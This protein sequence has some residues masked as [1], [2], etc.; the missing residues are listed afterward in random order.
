[1]NQ[2]F[3]SRKTLWGISIAGLLIAVLLICVFV[4]TT[5]SAMKEGIVLPDR[6]EENSSDELPEQTENTDFLEITPENVLTALHTL[7]RPEAYYQSCTVT[8]GVQPYQSAKEVHLWVNGDLLHAEVRDAHHTKHLLTDGAVAYIW[9]E[10]NIAPARILLTEY[11]TQEDLLGLP[12]FD[13]F[14][15]VEQEHI[16]DAGYLFL[17]E[18]NIPCI[19]VASRQTPSAV[20]RYWVNLDSGLLYQADAM[21]DSDQVYHVRQQSFELLSPE[22]DE[23]WSK[24]RLPD[25]TAPFTEAEQGQQP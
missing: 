17:D 24:M 16:T 7:E 13:G 19:Y 4:S 6:T 22:Q 21:E 20:V 23:L 8:V 25:G 18:S 9:Y 2:K 5:G 15:T 14:L 10:G 1:M 11:L 3:S 12:D